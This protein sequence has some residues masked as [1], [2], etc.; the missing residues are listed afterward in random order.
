MPG[1]ASGSAAAKAA[2]VR[3]R[4]CMR[5]PCSIATGNARFRKLLQHGVVA[6]APDALFIAI[7]LVR[8]CAVGNSSDKLSRPMR[9]V[10]RRGC[11][12]G[13]RVQPVSSA[14]MHPRDPDI[15][16]LGGGLAGGLIALAL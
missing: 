15:A 6:D 5:I 12:C 8:P 4:A 3:K 7:C 9:A 13:R 1:A 16:I 11:R 2:A 14:R 10:A